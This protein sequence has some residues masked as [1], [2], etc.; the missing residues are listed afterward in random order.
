MSSNYIGINGLV[1]ETYEESLNNLKQAFRQIYGAD[2][3]L[4]QNTSDGQWL[5]L[6]A[7]Q[8]QDMLDMIVQYY[9]NLDVDRVIGI[10]QQILYKLNGLTI[11]AYSYSYCYVTLD[12]VSPVTLQGLDDNIDSADGVGYTV[13]DSNGNEWILAESQTLTIGKHQ[14]N[15]RAALL[16]DIT[17]APNSIQTMITVIKGVSS[18][19]NDAVN[20]LTGAVGESD[21]QFRTRRNRSMVIPSQGFTDS[22]EAQLLNLDNVVDCKVYDNKESETI[23]AIPPHAVWVIV[24]GG[25]TVDIGNVIYANLPPGIPMKGEQVVNISKSN[26]EVQIIKF[27]YPTAVDLYI[28][29]NIKN[30]TRA[31]LDEDYIKQEMSKISFAIG[32][33]A[34]SVNLLATLKDILGETGTP[35]DLEVS[36]DGINYVEYITP[37][38]LDEYFT[39][40]SDNI[41]ITVI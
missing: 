2:V 30:F 20:Y 3:N 28:M 36:T 17:C 40:S 37:T 9:N 31:P 22:I 24:Q 38:G 7:Q 4:E 41:N 8:K 13:A 25:N 16:G 15:F 29:V 18:V 21:S 34:Q 6:L 12:V 32:E 33:M 39:I 10:P 14:L 26:G 23:N 19:N 27:D 1:T 11:K 35:Y 5:A